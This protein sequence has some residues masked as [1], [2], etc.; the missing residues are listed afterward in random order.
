MFMETESEYLYFIDSIYYIFYNINDGDC[1]ISMLKAY[2][3][4][5]IFILYYF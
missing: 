5:N 2:I 3:A 4:N 1:L